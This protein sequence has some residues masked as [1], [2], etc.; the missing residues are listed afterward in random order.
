[1]PRLVPPEPEWKKEKLQ[2]QEKI[3][4]QKLKIQKLPAN[5]TFVEQVEQAVRDQ[6]VY[7]RP[8]LT[9]ADKENNIRS[10][11][12]KMENRLYFIIKTPS[13]PH[14]Q[15]PALQHQKGESLRQTV[16]RATQSHVPN[17]GVYFLS[18]A[19]DVHCDF[20]E[21]GHTR[22][23]F[24]YRSYHLKGKPTLGEGAVDYAWE[25]KS[26]LKEYLDP[27]LYESVK[28]VLQDH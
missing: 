16:E 25:T 3:Q 6:G 8:R 7:D 18:N 27:V 20:P 21:K 11:N 10:L 13:T 5:I 17:F 1:M 9:K 12:R 23:L 28:D 26:E 19:P 22:R 24:L 4:S 14:W 2:F 15:F